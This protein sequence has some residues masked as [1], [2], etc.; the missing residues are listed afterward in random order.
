MN[1][2]IITIFPEAFDSFIKT[3]IIGKSLK[4]NLFNIELYKLNDFSEKNF[5][6]VDGKA[7]CPSP[8]QVVRSRTLFLKQ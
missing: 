8:G 6:H 2:H 3:S 7:C 1:F 4:N 5:K